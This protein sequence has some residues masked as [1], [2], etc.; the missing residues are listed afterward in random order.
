MVFEGYCNTDVVRQWVKAL[1]L[2]ALLPGQVVIWDNASFHQNAD[3]RV[4]IES[5]GCRLI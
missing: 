4:M 1:L 3:F 2:A 5:A